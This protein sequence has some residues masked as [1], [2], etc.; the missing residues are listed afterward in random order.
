MT[1]A[2]HDT[3]SAKDAF[4]TAIPDGVPR[5]AIHVVLNVFQTI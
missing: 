1:Q 4:L 3:S 2:V 5:D